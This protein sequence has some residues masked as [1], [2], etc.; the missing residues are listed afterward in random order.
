MSVV[1]VGSS[2]AVT[3]AVT[4]K[5]LNKM[6]KS[7]QEYVC[8]DCGQ[9]YKQ[10]VGKCKSCG[11]WNT[12]KEVTI[13]KSSGKSIV[14]SRTFDQLEDL[15]SGATITN[16]TRSKTNISELDRVLGGGLVPG[17]A[18]LLSGEPG[19]GK[20]T[21]LLQLCNSTAS[22]GI[23]T[24]YVTGEESI[25]QIRVRA[26]RMAVKGK[27]KVIATTDINEILTVI[28]SME[29]GGIAIIDSIQTIGSDDVDSS[30]GSI[31]QVK[32]CTLSLVNAA[33]SLGISIVIVGHINK[34]GQIAG[35]KLLEH[36]VDVVLSFET[37]NTN[38]YRIIRGLKNRYGS[39]NEMGIFEMSGGGLIEVVNPSKIFMP[40]S[41]S[42]ISGSCV[43]AGIEGTRG[44]LIE[45]QALVA[46]SYIPT[47]R[48]AAIGWD[49]N[50]LSMIIAILNARVGIN[51]LDKEIYLNV[52]GGTKVS[53]TGLDLAV[54]VA[55]ISAH[56][57]ITIPHDMAFVGE[58][59]LL[60][61]IR[62]VSHLDV[63]IKEAVKLGFKT[64][65]T[66]LPEKLQ[67]T[68]GNVVNIKNIRDI[69]QLIMR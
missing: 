33:K 67:P 44:I 39:T 8:G 63:R 23:A 60:G 3:E 58:V 24:C 16:L 18:V 62:T 7:K 6:K 27:I 26:D 69:V 17:T 22:Q 65:V 66:A 38:Q 5:K 59:G 19:I 4:I 54:A 21:L 29:C 10:W 34:E 53:D 15:T 48:R 37:D 43:F 49:Y 56:K 12:I 28:R 64:I 31:A 45:V 25:D 57:N 68:E 50:R 47:P 14:S 30:P 55:L 20:S 42:N 1:T 32:A 51:I 61:E 2:M 13:S 46:P 35:P 36:M 40:S 52:A 41:R 11:Q 9:D